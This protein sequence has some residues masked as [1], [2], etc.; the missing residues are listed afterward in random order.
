[1]KIY[2]F[3]DVKACEFINVFMQKNDNMAMRYAQAVIQNP[4]NG[5]MAVTPEDFELYS[6]GDFNVE[7][8]DLHVTSPEF[9]KNLLE[10]KQ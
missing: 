3:K 6:L 5:V 10:L 2:A 9:I 4:S 8:G 1:M 7:N